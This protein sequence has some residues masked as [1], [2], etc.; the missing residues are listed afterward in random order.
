MT[1]DCHWLYQKFLRGA[2]YVDD[3]PVWPNTSECAG[4]IDLIQ[5]PDDGVCAG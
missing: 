2:V 4:E 3:L 5:F 1:P